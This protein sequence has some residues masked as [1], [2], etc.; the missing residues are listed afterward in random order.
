MPPGV[1]L[2]Q[3]YKPQ[4]E[5]MAKATTVTTTRATVRPMHTSSARIIRIEVPRKGPQDIQAPTPLV[6]SGES[7]CAQRHRASNLSPI[8]SG[9]GH[10]AAN[11][12]R[13]QWATLNLRQVWADAAFMRGHLSVAGLQVKSSTEPATVNRLKTKL[14]SIGVHSPE[15][16]D[17]IGMPLMKFLKVNPG[18]PLWAALALVLESIGRF[19]PEV[20]CPAGVPA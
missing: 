18:L 9:K 14:R 12:K 4:K 17:A 7:I 13:A 8:D 10:A 20:D 16:Q 5:L 2:F 1:F 15:I 6:P 19:S 11:A 3:L